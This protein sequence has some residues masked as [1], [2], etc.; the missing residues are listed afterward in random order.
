MSKRGILTL[1]AIQILLIAAAVAGS[2][3][4]QFYVAVFGFPFAEIGKLMRFLLQSGK[5]G[6]AFAAL[7][8]GAL[9]LT[10]GQRIY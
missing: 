6:S 4:P 2:V 7:L 1:A 3:Y 9:S 5:I 10:P 8:W